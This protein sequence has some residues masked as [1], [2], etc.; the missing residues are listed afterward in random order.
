MSDAQM[1]EFSKP[2]ATAFALAIVAEEE[3]AKAFLLTLVYKGLVQWNA[4]IW[5]AARDHACKQLLGMVM[6]YM[7]PDLEEF[8]KHINGKDD[9]YATELLPSHIAD[10]LNILRHEKIGR[11]E[12]QNW[13]WD[14]PPNYDAKAK[15]VA[16]GPIDRIKQDQLYVNLG[17]DCSFV[18]KPVVSE[19]QF[20]REKERAERLCS[21]V[22]SMVEDDQPNSIEVQ[23]VI[24]A[25]RILFAD[26][27]STGN[28]P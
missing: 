23:K 10:A 2:P 4:N 8:I 28:Q 1:I 14:E 5:R 27:P 12:A 20:D 18:T 9:E 6:D 25:F 22:K 11:W 21:L 24:G 13:V 15:K 19:A 7:N 16:K 3:F 17:R 26:Y